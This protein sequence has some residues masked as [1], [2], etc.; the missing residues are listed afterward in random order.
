MN[1]PMITTLEIQLQGESPLGSD[2][3][4]VP[5]DGYALEEVEKYAQALK[6]KCIEITKRCAL[7]SVTDYTVKMAIREMA[8]NSEITAPKGSGAYR[9]Q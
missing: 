5:W 3:C 2:S 7:P 1:T 4:S 8:Q 6:A 9:Q